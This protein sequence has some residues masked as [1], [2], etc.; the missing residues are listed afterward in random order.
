M[1]KLELI[2]LIIFKHALN[3][4]YYTMKRISIPEFE[5]LTVPTNHFQFFKIQ[6]PNAKTWLQLQNGCT[7][8][9]DDKCEYILCD[10]FV[11]SQVCFYFTIICKRDLKHQFFFIFLKSR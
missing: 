8:D 3:I 9:N 10:I 1:E 2:K 6:I 7:T 5:R 4:K 11:A